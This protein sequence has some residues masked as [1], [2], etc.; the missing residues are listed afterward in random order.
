[1]NGENVERLL[2]EVEAVAGPVAWP[3]VEALVAALVDLYGEGLGRTIACAREAARGEAELDDLL[4]RDEL[5][6]GL[7]LLHDLHPLTL[8]RRVEIA[9]RRVRAQLPAAAELV[10]VG[11][12]DGIVK[13][14]VA[15]TDGPPDGR[16]P[17]TTI[18]A[19]E[20]ERDAP[21][22]AGVQIDSAVPPSPAGTGF[23]PIER[24]RRGGRP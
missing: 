17:P 7:L 2:E 1:M 4:A 6:A 12:D 16:P 21:E 5:V 24:L 14:R 20:I 13:L 10:L 15:Q 19:R 8:E 23:V 9:L 22:V 11:V 18:V 3:R